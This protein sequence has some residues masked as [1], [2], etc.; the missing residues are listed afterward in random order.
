VKG[1]HHLN[2]DD[3][4]AGVDELMV[5]LGGVGPAPG[6]GEGVKLRLAYFAAGLAEENVVIG[7]E[8]ERR[9][10]IDEIDARVRELARVAQPAE[11]IAEIKPVHLR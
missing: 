11:V 9:I 10:E 3:V 5:G 6:I 7:V 4:L 1:F 8:I 2:D